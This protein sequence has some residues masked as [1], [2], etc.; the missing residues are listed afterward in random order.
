MGI[1]IFK[2]KIKSHQSTNP[3]NQGSDI[4]HVNLTL[5]FNYFAAYLFEVV[6]LVDLNRGSV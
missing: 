1:S 2:D 4:N 3:T 6:Y 5:I